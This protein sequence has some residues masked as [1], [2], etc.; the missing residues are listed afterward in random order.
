M[1]SKTR[2]GRGFKGSISI[3]ASNNR[4][5]LHF[6]HGGKRH[7]L[8]LGVPDTKEARKFAEMKAREIELDIFSG[9]FD[10]TLKKYRPQT[11]LSVDSPDIQPKVPLSLAEVWDKFVE[12]KRPQCSPNTML[13]VYGHFTKYVK[14]L[15][16]HDISK[17]SE[18][19]DFALKEFPLDSCKRFIKRLNACCNWAVKSGLFDENPFA[20]MATEIKLPKS[21][22]APTRMMCFRLPKRSVT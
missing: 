18:I 4:L 13:Y 12:Y 10:Q 14:R 21:K 22:K 16:T 19:T 20:G 17:A 8:S 1:F 2:S 7:Y 11:A 6:R 15:P 9:H 3:V 5:Q